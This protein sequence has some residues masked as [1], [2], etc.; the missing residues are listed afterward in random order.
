MRLRQSSRVRIGI[1]VALALAVS[2]RAEAAPPGSSRLPVERVVRQ[3][4]LD[5]RGNVPEMADY[6]AVEGAADV[7]DALV[8][9][10]LGSDEFRVQM[11]RYHEALLWTNPSVSLTSVTTALG[12][13]TIDG[14]S[15]YRTTGRRSLYRG[16]DGTVDCQAK[17]Q[18]ILGYEPDGTPK[19]EDFGMASG[20]PVRREGYVEV[21]PYWEANPAVTIK[22]CAF[23][24]QATETF[25]IASG[26]EAGTYSCNTLQGVG[27]S[28]RCGC[29]PNLA[30]CTVTAVGNAVVAA[31]REQLLR[32]VD[33]HTVGG[34]PYSQLLTSKRAYVN[35]PLSHFLSYVAHTLPLSSIQVGLQPA[36]GDVP[37]VPYG[38]A[39]TWVAFEREAPHSGI[40]TLPAYLLRY[41]TLRGR[42]NRY[43]IA[44][45][46]QYFEPPSTQDSGCLEVGDDLTQRCV[47]RGCHTT[48][49]PLAAHFGKFTEA[50]SMSLAHFPES[51]PTR[52]A[53]NAGL[54][55]SVST[56]CD[57]FYSLVPALDDPDLRFWKLKPLRYA[58]AAHPEV[59]PSFDAGP[60]GLAQA[61]IASGLFHRSAVLQ[62]FEF[63]MKRPANLD[64]TSPDYEGLTLEAIAADFQQ[65]DD[66]KKAVLALVKLPAYRRLP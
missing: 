26:T 52:A 63:L 19:A 56:F 62:L 8:E 1:G 35:G 60:E 40:L 22:V 57:R 65:H 27:R 36:D 17:P 41:Q 47:C 53:C 24:A 51:F 31:F 45:R 25:M 54:V 49:E 10:Y 33:D 48:L 16:G 44:F 30:F 13:V 2:A 64:V 37:S 59:K 6:D 3:L 18:S 61:D 9:S 29:G 4:S 15:I 50:G 11:R 32:S 43:R 28:A 66:L 12:P 14:V 38:D 42:A 58:D 34:A 55:P 21:H 7:P 23:D 39:T 5:L 20:K 46:G